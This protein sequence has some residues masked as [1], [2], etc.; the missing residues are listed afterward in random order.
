VERVLESLQIGAAHM[1]EASGARNRG[2]ARA[3]KARRVGAKDMV[4]AS[5]AKS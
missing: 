4:E 3:P 5:G 1:G 2:A